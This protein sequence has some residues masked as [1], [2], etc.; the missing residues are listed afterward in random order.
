V[1]QTTEAKA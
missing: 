1:E